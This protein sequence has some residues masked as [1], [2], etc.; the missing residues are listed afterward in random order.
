MPNA[1]WTGTLS[2]GLVTLPVKLFPATQ[3][4]DVRFHLYDRE[5]RRV[6][7][8]RVVG[9]EP[10]VSSRPPDPDRDDEIETPDPTAR[11]EAPPSIERG[12]PGAAQ[13]S[14]ADE[15]A[16][17]EIVRGVEDPDTGGIVMLTRDELEEVRPQRS[18]SIDVEDFVELG[19]IDPVFFEKTY[20][21]V[22]TSL[23]ALRPYA[24]LLKAMERAGRVGIG[25]FVL[26]TK[27]HLVAIRPMR[28]AIALETLFF[29]DEVRDPGALVPPVDVEVG[30]RELDLAERLIDTLKTEWDPAAY[31][32]TYREE[33][34]RRIAEKSPTAP[35]EQPA[36]EPGAS[37]GAAVEDLM[38]AL[39]ESVDAAKARTQEREK[40]AKPRS[41]SRRRTG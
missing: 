8:R 25:R 36:A 35:Q 14:A 4:K 23:E 34:L 31:A 9:D 2:F 37:A 7:Y 6:R 3:P 27:P 41:T 22:P 16:W 30:D 5:G 1:V 13:S 26:R 21:V 39:R 11:D 10:G 19:D 24:L 40:P 20:Y 33:L 32:D 12:D 18:R 15:V 38:R 17:D 28:G 29:G